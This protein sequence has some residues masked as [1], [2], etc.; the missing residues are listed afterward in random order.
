MENVSQEPF[1]MNKERWLP[2]YEIPCGL[3]EVT[4]KQVDRYPHV[5]SERMSELNLRI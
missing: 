1:E 2:G 4:M 3:H 5:N